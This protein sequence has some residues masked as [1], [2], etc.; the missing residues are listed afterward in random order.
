[1]QPGAQVS[2][3]PL[4]P[5]VEGQ[6]G[7]A[8]APA[9]SEG[10]LRMV[11]VAVIGPAC[12]Q[13]ERGGLEP[14]TLHTQHDVALPQLAQGGKKGGSSDHLDWLFFQPAVPFPAGKPILLPL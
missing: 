11:P 14:R 9:G 12:L 7:M 2:L 3:C 5:I 10:Q 8:W 6:D 1:M 4:L 13:A